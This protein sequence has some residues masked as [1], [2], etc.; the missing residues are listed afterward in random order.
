M[1]VR[2]ADTGNVS[3]S[4]KPKYEVRRGF[5]APTFNLPSECWEVWHRGGLFVHERHID[6]FLTEHGAQSAVDKMNRKKR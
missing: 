3:M 5:M 4:R 2:Q 1:A 6:T